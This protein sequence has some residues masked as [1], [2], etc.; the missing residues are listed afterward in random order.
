MQLTL[1]MYGAVCG[2]GFGCVGVWVWGRAVVMARVC[3]STCMTEAD[4]GFRKGGIEVTKMWPM[5]EHVRNVF[6]FFIKFRF[7]DPPVTA[8][9][10][11][12]CVHVLKGHN[13]QH[14]GH[15]GQQISK[16]INS[17]NLFQESS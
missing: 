5:R 10:D 12:L 17:W 16:W 13:M 9:R 6:P 8:P 4:T 11:Y 1:H 2:C 3:V 7:P 15:T 14:S